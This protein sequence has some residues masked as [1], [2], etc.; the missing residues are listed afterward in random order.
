MTGRGYRAADEFHYQIDVTHGH[1]AKTRVE[2]LT[3]FGR[4]IFMRHP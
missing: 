3:S 1:R 4:T 2:I